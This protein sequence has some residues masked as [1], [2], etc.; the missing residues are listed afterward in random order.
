MS[1]PHALRKRR[2]QAKA[3][4]RSSSAK[5]ESRLIKELSCAIGRIQ[6]QMHENAEQIAV[7]TGLVDL[8][9]LLDDNEVIPHA[10]EPKYTI[11]VEYIGKMVDD[12]INDQTIVVGSA[13]GF[14][15]STATKQYVKRVK[16]LEKQRRKAQRLE[17]LGAVVSLPDTTKPDFSW[18]ALNVEQLAAAS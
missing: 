11:R 18:K 6:R 1:N 14:H 15:L 12:M 5:Y 7:S 9:R 10:V 3:K 4:T 17:S 2:P 8:I 13:G 16:R